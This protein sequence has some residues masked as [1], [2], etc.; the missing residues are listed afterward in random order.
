[1]NP[2]EKEVTMRKKIRHTY[3]TIG[4]IIILLVSLIHIPV[5]ANNVLLNETIQRT[6]VTKGLIYEYKQKFTR[7]GWVDIHVLIMDLKEEQVA[8]NVLRSSDTFGLRETMSGLAS[9]DNRVVAAM[10]GSFFNTTSLIS[11]PIGVEYNSGFVSSLGG[12]NTTTLGA[13]SLIQTNDGNINFDFLGVSYSFRNEA[14]ATMTVGGINRISTNGT[15]MIYNAISGKDTSRIDAL[16]D[17][18]K[19]V[20]MNDSVTEVVEP[21]KIAMIPSLETGGYVVAIPVALAPFHLSNFLVGT[22]TSLTVNSNI[23]LSTVK[24]ALSGGGKILEKGVVVQTGLIVEPTKRH[25]RSAIGLSTDQ[26]KLIAM[27]VDGRGK[28]MGATHS[29]LANYLIEYKVSD[30]IHMDGGGSST[31]LRREAGQTVVTVANTVAGGTQRKIING[32]GFVSLAEIGPVARIQI[33]PASVKTF[34][35]TGVNFSLLGFDKNDNPV[36]INSKKLVWTM[37]GI[38][39]KWELNNFTPTTIGIGKLTAY[40]EGI[41]AT[42]TIESV[43]SP[44]SLTVSPKVMSL[45]YNEKASFTIKGFDNTGYFGNVNATDV[46]YTLQNPAIGSFANGIFT[47]SGVSGLSKVT[48]KSKYST[49]TAYI[50]VGYTNQLVPEFETTAFSDLSYPVGNITGKISLDTTTFVDTNQG[51][52]MDYNFKSSSDPQ[53]YYMVMDSLNFN[54]SIEKMSIHVF[55][56]GSGHMF[57]GRILDAD[58]TEAVVTF[59]S[60]MDWTGWK[61]LTAEIP[62]TLKYPIKL[63]RLYVVSMST[64]ID[65][66]GT[67]YMDALSVYAGIDSKSIKF[68]R[69]DFINDS[70][71]V[72]SKPADSSGIEDFWPYSLS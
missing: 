69:E 20:I 35:N 52:R 11:D 53:A 5:E 15:P 58:N 34:I 18:Y 13:S 14:Q 56:N 17:F 54:Q 64:D 3:K 16:G 51:Y 48:I 68:D 6:T 30:A 21:K 57:R 71:R 24:L 23:D 22:K 63:E 44:I 7:D 29:E 31:M 42:T 45:A 26:T 10:N 25:P 61:V 66:S 38:Q 72:K 28:S 55:G 4:L 37:E 46:T 19:L 33:V 49:T 47:A 39:G 60:N 65:F 27:V 50:G 43:D 67:V 36:T 9:K 12:Y 70:F 59:S 8:F 1:M 62:S 41:V 32:V 40:Y 2:I